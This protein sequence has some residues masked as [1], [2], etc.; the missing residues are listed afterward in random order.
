MVVIRT[1]EPAGN[2]PSVVPEKAIQRLVSL[3]FK[4]TRGALEAA[5]VQVAA[6]TANFKV[7]SQRSCV[8]CRDITRA[9]PQ[10]RK[11]GKASQKF[12]RA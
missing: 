3:C 9:A 6:T 1:A 10:A 11:R 7:K 12:R 5:A 2:L 4:I 8:C